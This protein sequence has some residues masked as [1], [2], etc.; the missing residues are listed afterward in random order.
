MTTGA[1]EVEDNGQGNEGQPNINPKWSKL[2]EVLPESLHGLV[3]P[4]LSEWDKGVQEK[5]TELHNQYNPY[6]EFVES[7]VDPNQINQSLQLAQAIQED[8]AGV[9]E[10]MVEHFKLEQFKAQQQVP[11]PD[12][13][14]LDL[15]DLGSVDIETLKKHPAFKEVFAAAEKAE[16]LVQTQQQTLQQQQAAEQFQEYME[17][18]HEKYDDETTGFKF[19]E[20]FVTTLIASGIDGD[21]A[22]E[23]YKAVL[24]QA[25]AGF[26]PV[27]TNQPP[28]VTPPVVMG[29]SGNNGAGVPDQAVKM[30]NLKVDDLNNMVTQMLAA[31]AQ[32]NPNN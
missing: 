31:A 14:D 17:S 29:G 6:K 1:P 12:L 3:T 16:Q 21:A 32:E 27:N 7:K 25:R 26:V 18:L 19:D 4:H 30:G 11:D 24:D 22:V 23:Q 5:I 8:P 28:K 9:V 2:L 20:T 15:G 13:D 10:R